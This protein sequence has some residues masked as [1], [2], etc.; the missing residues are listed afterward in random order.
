MPIVLL[1]APLIPI[2]Y[3]LFIKKWDTVFLLGERKAGKDTL[4]HIL[5]GDGF[6]EN[7]LALGQAQRVSI[8]I[9]WKKID[10]I[11]AVRGI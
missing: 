10:I 7:Y 1:A 9:K 3:L 11:K 5:K 8:R 2:G 6:Q 4:L